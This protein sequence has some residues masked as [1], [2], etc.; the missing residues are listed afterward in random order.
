MAQVYFRCSSADQILRNRCQADVN[1]LTEAR[2]QAQQLVRSLIA[3]PGPEDWR[4]WVLH[5]TDDLD[6]EI[7]ALPFTALMGRLH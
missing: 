2:E 4:H 6:E 7:F 5:V 3:M 1:D